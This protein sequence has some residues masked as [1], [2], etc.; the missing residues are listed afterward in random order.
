MKLSEK[1]KTETMPPEKDPALNKEQEEKK[2]KR[3]KNLLEILII[4]LIILAAA[5]IKTGT[6][7]GLTGLIIVIKAVISNRIY[8]EEEEEGCRESAKR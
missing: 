5:I 6:A 7:F 1:P 2:A 8:P 4:L 3:T